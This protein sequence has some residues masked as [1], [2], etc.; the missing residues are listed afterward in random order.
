[1]THLASLLRQCLSEMMQKSGGGGMNAM[2]PGAGGPGSVGELHTQSVVAVSK[3]TRA[4]APSFIPSSLLA[5]KKYYLGDKEDG[6]LCNPPEAA[7]NPLQNM[8]AKDPTALAGM[9]KYNIGYLILNGGLAYLISF[10]FSDSVVAKTPFPLTATF[11][12]LLQRGIEVNDLDTTYVSAISW[13]FLTFFCSGS[14]SFLL[15]RLLG[16]ARESS[17]ADLDPMLA[18]MGGGNSSP[19]GP[20]QPGA[21]FGEEAD[22]W[23]LMSHTAFFA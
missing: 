10:L 1:M 13:Y 19:F 21:V 23:K 20:Q 7:S 18:M 17:L 9:M 15:T 12:P 22:S 8:M 4:S 2:M 6:L 14:Y 11:K 3:L 16:S 5:R